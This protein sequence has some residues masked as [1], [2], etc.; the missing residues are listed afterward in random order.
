MSRE[1]RLRKALSLS[2]DFS[3]FEMLAKQH[4]VSVGA[5]LCVR[6]KI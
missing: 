1:S 3:G 4:S 6:H 5:D 2:Q